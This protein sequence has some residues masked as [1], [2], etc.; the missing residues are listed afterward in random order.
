MK[1]GIILRNT[2]T[3]LCSRRLFSFTAD[4]SDASEILLDGNMIFCDLFQFFMD[5]NLFCYRLSEELYRAWW[6]FHIDCKALDPVLFYTFYGETD[7]DDF[8]D[9]TI[10]Q[11]HNMRQE[12]RATAKIFKRHCYTKRDGYAKID[13]FF[14]D[15]I[16]IMYREE[17][18]RDVFII[19][20]LV[21]K[22]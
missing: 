16:D 19:T 2:L 11:F 5:F 7:E 9:I 3:R 12:I 13:E 20:G 17:F 8:G 6:R 14:G 18:I 22:F 15:G 4:Q 1:N 21:I 10:R